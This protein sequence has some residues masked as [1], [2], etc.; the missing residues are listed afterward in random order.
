[1]K[2]RKY[3]FKGNPE[4]LSILSVFLFE[5]GFEGVEDKGI[6]MHDF[7]KIGAENDLLSPQVKEFLHLNKI[8]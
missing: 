3:V 4:M 1:M 8:E 5:D 2:Y 6:E 7:I